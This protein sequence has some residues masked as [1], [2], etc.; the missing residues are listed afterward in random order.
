MT[1]GIIFILGIV[2]G[3][4]ITMLSYRLPINEDIV[5]TPS[6]CANCYTS[7]KPLDLIPLFSWI[8]SFGKCRHC[9]I[10]ISARY[11]LIELSTGIIFVLISLEKDLPYEGF[12]LLLS[13]IILITIIIISLKYDTTLYL[14]FE[15]YIIM[16]GM[17]YG[18]LQYEGFFL[19]LLALGLIA[20]TVIDLE[21]KIIPNTLQIYILILGVVHAFLQTD[22]IP[23]MIGG[24]IGACLGLV[25]YYGSLFAL[26]KEGLGF[27]DVKF[28]AIAG[29]WIG[30]TNFIPFITYAGIFGIITGVFWQ[31]FSKNKQFPFA[32]SLVLSLFLCLLYPNFT[33][34]YWETIEKMVS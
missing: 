7:L 23:Y 25:L 12:L 22:F 15:L 6:H 28:L 32:P 3:S 33:V 11:P 1:I 2:F 16:L 5:K 17:L 10:K 27:G 13:T 18:V 31:I 26:K 8:F 14:T 20:I 21:Y 9:G 24:T 34:F 29:L 30:H 19:L 4:F